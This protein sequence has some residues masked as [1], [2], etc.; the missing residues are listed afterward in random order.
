[1]KLSDF[2]SNKIKHA[3]SY[4]CR[5][6]PLAGGLGNLP[7][8]SSTGK[9]NPPRPERSSQTDECTLAGVRVLVL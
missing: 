2:R 9:A 6:L 8:Y 1:M 7:H 3:V 4:Q 5:L